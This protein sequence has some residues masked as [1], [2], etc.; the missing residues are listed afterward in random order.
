MGGVIIDGSNENIKKIINSYYY[1]KYALKAVAQFIT[2]ENI[3]EI[4]KKYIPYKSIGLL[5]IDIDG[6]DYWI[7]NELDELEADIL[8]CEF[9]PWFGF[10]KAIT[11]PYIENFVRS[12]YTKTYSYYGAS[13][14]AI[15]KLAEKKGYIYVGMSIGGQNAFFVNKK[16][17]NLIKEIDLPKFNEAKFRNPLNGIMVDK[18]MA[19]E[20]WKQLDLKIFDVDN[21]QYMLLKDILEELD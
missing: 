10:K 17:E 9:N 5:S 18:K 6:N 2:K 1:W 13:F 3:N 14:K 19:R 12:N 16:Y 8:I 7:L 15:K 21:N 11:I 4:A 20:E